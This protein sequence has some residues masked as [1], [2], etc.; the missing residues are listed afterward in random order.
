MLPAR[1]RWF[2]LYFKCLLE[3]SS[4]LLPLIH[5][6][7]CKIMDGLLLLRPVDDGLPRHGSECK[8]LLL[9]E[10]P[11]SEWAGSQV[12]PNVSRPQWQV[13]KMRKHRVFEGFLSLVPKSVLKIALA[14]ACHTLFPREKSSL[15]FVSLPTEIPCWICMFA[16]CLSLLLFQTRHCD[17]PYMTYLVSRVSATFNG[18]WLGSSLRNRKKAAKSSCQTPVKA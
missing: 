17:P 6:P 15:A 8:R 3:S 10:G 12:D 11:L 5:C 16:N 7:V 14:T 1:G 13:C 4:L 2:N 9:L 18:S